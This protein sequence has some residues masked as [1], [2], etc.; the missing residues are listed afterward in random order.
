M[1]NIRFIT[2]I[3]CKLI[4]LESLFLAICFVLSLYYRESDMFAF[5]ISTLITASTAIIINSSIKV[6][7]TVLAKKDGYFIVTLV[8]IIISLFGSLPYIIGN[9]IPSFPDAFFETMSGFTT[10]GSTIMENIESMPHATLFWRSLTQWLGGLGI[11]VLFLALIQSLGI[12]GRDLYVAE[13]TGPTHSKIT[14]TFSSTARSLWMIYVGLTILEAILLCLGG[15]SIFDSICNSFTTM[16]TGGFSTKQ[17][18]IAYWSSPYIQYVITFFMFIAGVNFSLTYGLITKWDWKRFFKDNE[19][20]VYCS[21]VILSTLIIFASLYHNNWQGGDIEHIFRDSIFQVITTI[22]TTGF[23]TTDYMLW[24]PVTWCVIILIM[25]IG[26]CASSTAGGPKVIRI[27]LLV[28]NSFAELERIIHPNAITTVKYNKKV[29]PSNTIS[30]IMGFFTLFVLIIVISTLI[31]VMSNN[32]LMTSFSGVITSISNVGP[33][34]GSIGPSETFAN[35]NDF[36]KIFLAFIM[37]IGRLEI[38]TVLVIFTRSFW[39]N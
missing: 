24:K 15:M 31:L 23:A 37:L 33:G 35:M 28:K 6:N 17:A 30:N 5:A 2:K 13:T 22:T 3:M 25:C 9:T 8:W 36:S 7:D 38:F 1:I 27:S 26:A 39:K 16:A 19:F 10:T 18:S 21:I 34:F 11:I 4:L 32:D 29:V 14:N 12:E 20:K